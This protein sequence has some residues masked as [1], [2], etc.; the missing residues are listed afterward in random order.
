VNYTRVAVYSF[1]RH[2]AYP[3]S[4]VAESFTNTVFGFVRASILLALWKA[5]P[6]LGGYDATDAVTFCFLTQ[7]LLGPVQIFGGI[8]L[9]ERI[10]SGD[11]AV[12]LHR[13]ADLQAWWLADDVG[14]ALC[15]MAM[16]A[17]LPL[18]A[19]A[20]F[21]R[22]YWPPPSALAAFAISFLLAV[23]TSFALRYPV[24]LAIFWLHDDRGLN[25]V[26]LVTSMFFSGMILPLVIFP[27]GIAS[28][29][30]ALPWAGLIQIP[31]GVYLGK[32]GLW[33]ALAVQGAWA[34]ALLAGGRAL[35]LAAR[36]KLVIHGG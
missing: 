19:G 2:A 30:M 18:L 33:H 24:A 28:A 20:L 27:S 22:L 3:L 9:A 15:T 16:R 29:A 10:R 1:K 35:T 23:L 7:A 17:A 26:M 13:P 25:A 5:R 12:D 4:A 21:F 34:G 31:A 36:R 32:I 6:A 14:R 8:E 11:V